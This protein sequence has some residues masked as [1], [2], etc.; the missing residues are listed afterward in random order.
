VR[1]ECCDVRQRL[2]FV[3]ILGEVTRGDVDPPVSRYNATKEVRSDRS[4]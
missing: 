1:T 4:N 3:Y 2:R